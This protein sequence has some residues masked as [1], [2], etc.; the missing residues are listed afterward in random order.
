MRVR[1]AV[2]H[3][4]G[5]LDWIYGLPCK[6]AM[7]GDV[8]RRSPIGPNLHGR[9]RGPR[10]SPHTATSGLPARC[11]KSEDPRLYDAA[12]APDGTSA[13][14]FGSFPVPVSG[15]TGSAQTPAGSD[16]SWYASWAPARRPR[17]VVVVL[18]EH[19]GFGAEA[20]APAAQEIYSSF[21]RIR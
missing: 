21:F 6:H 18:I 3:V 2:L 14:V 4:V 19:G 15:K 13:S 9:P 5:R 10:L 11:R 8:L 12:H 16:H 20:A 1:H 7:T 17:I